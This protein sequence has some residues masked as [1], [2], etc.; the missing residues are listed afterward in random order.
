M[1]ASGCGTRLV[2]KCLRR[3]LGTSAKCPANR[4]SATQPGALPWVSGQSELQ[5][6]L[7]ISTEAFF[8]HD[9][10]SL[11]SS[12]AAH[13]V[14]ASLLR[15]QIAS[16]SNWEAEDLAP[17]KLRQ[18]ALN[19]TNSLALFVCLKFVALSLLFKH[20][21]AALCPRLAARSHAPGRTGPCCPVQL[22]SRPHQSPQCCHNQLRGNQPSAC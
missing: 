10:S 12:L 17:N 20:N 11:L 2:L 7:Q 8:W 14:F 18:S 9:F 13:W 16:D 21:L 19:L 4:R 1:G 22:T 3:H 5:E 15:T 6:L